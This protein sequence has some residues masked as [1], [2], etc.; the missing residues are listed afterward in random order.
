MGGTRCGFFSYGNIAQQH[1]TGRI[2]RDKGEGKQEN[3]ALL[4]SHLSRMHGDALEQ[5]SDSFVFRR[6]PDCYSWNNSTN[7]SDPISG[8][9][10]NAP[11]NSTGGKNFQTSASE[12]RRYFL[13]MV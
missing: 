12:S 4:N 13:R 8:T 3:P 5:D 6:H 11:V 10:G 7:S 2:I 9:I 1:P